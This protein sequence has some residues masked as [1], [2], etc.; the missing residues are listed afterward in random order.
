[1]SG[2]SEPDLQ[3]IRDLNLRFWAMQE[4]KSK[5]S[6]KAL[7]DQNQELLSRQEMLLG[8]LRTERKALETEF[9]QK[10]PKFMELRKPAVI[11][12]DELQKNVLTPDE[13]ILSYW[14]GDEELYAF[15]VDQKKINT[16]HLAISQQV[17]EEIF[18][19]TGQE[20]Y[21][22]LLAPFLASQTMDASRTL[23]I[24]PHD[25]L[26]TVPFES[27]LVSGKGKTFKDLDYF[28]NHVNIVYV[29]SATVLRAIR[30]DEKNQAL[31]KKATQP[32]LLL[33]DPVYSEDQLKKTPSQN[34]E[35]SPASRSLRAALNPR[36][37]DVALVLKNL[38][39]TK[40]HPISRAIRFASD[41]RVSLAPL[42]GTRTEV[43]TISNALYSSKKSDS[44]L[45]GPDALESKIKTLNEAQ[46]LLDYKYL[47]FACHGILPN[48]VKGLAEP[49]L[50][51]SMYG[52]PKEDGFLKMGEIFGLR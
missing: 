40:D 45:L 42:P 46:T 36:A 18:K 28:F 21:Q 48:E 12:L 35:E 20:L 32:A 37:Q 11:T 24:I 4:L 41:G 23:I 19:I 22:T 6:R 16:F 31:L 25:V 5:E 49:C 30:N 1:M 33:G 38:D 51:L 2:I 52:D 8:E 17:P 43:E 34:P 26:S 44:I 9:G 47:H 10:Y 29:P 14:V 13:T 39:S 50:A 27:L 15:I 3:R 7:K